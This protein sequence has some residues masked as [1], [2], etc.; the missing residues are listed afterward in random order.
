MN[1]EIEEVVISYKA[2]FAPVK[3]TFVV[4]L[5]KIFVVNGAKNRFVAD[6]DSIDEAVIYALNKGF[7][8]VLFDRDK[9]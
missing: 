8:I 9:R 2:S 6:F 7:K 3:E 5:V 4:G 1:T